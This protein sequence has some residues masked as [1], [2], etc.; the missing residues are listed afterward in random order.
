V[1]NKET[2]IRKPG[3]LGVRF[4]NIPITRYPNILI[5]SPQ[6]ISDIAYFFINL[7]NS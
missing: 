6:L 1:K 2:A 3:Y 5:F 7:K 4:P